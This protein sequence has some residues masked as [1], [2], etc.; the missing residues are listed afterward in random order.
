[1]TL[2]STTE[3]VTSGTRFVLCTGLFGGQCSGALSLWRN[4]SVE[5][6]VWQQAGW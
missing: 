4:L 6:A 2:N 5:L 3:S 1:M